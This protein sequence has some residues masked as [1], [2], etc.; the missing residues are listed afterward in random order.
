M[1][2][3]SAQERNAIAMRHPGTSRKRDAVLRAWCADQRLGG[4]KQPS[5]AN[6]TWFCELRVIFYR[7]LMVF[8]GFFGFLFV[9]SGDFL[10]LALLRYLLGIIWIIFSRLLEGKSK[11]RSDS[12]AL[13]SRNVLE[14]TPIIRPPAVK[15]IHMVNL[16][17]ASNR[18]GN[19]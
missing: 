4:A 11:V 16:S 1:I 5:E 2:T 15:P 14:R 17:A 8:K 10:F 6:V 12:L 13:A 19:L 18:S 7:V 9:F 3:P